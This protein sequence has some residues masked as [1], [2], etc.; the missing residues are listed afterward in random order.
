M[1]TFCQYCSIGGTGI[2]TMENLLPMKVNIQT[3]MSYSSTRFQNNPCVTAVCIQGEESRTGHVQFRYFT[4]FKHEL[5]D[6]FTGGFWIEGRFNKEH[7]VLTNLCIDFE[8]GRVK[9]LFQVLKIGNDPTVDGVRGEDRADLIC[10]AANDV[11]I[12]VLSSSDDGSFHVTGAI[13]PRK[14]CS[15]EL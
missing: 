8:K 5:S 3:Y 11:S 13:V 14:T 9:D 2:L 10:C 15:R 12:V 1:N 7:G 4:C 6:A